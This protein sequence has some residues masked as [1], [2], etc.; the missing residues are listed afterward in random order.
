MVDH[1]VSWAARIAH[2]GRTRCSQSHQPG[3]PP[4]STL[5]VVARATAVSKATG[6]TTST[7]P[8]RPC[9]HI[10]VVSSVVVFG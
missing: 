2:G 6:H 10:P 8:S 9:L 5:L 7:D 4:P 1:C 3:Q